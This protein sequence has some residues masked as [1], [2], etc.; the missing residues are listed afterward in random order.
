MQVLAN[1]DDKDL[2]HGL[3]VPDA[4]KSA[5]GGDAAGGSEGTPGAGG[6][7]AIGPASFAFLEKELRL[8]PGGAGMA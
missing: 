3:P 4:L 6:G 1:V 5:P 7:P 8:A 2:F